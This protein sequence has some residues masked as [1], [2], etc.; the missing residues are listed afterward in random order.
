MASMKIHV[1]TQELEG[2]A[3]RY[4]A[5]RDKC[6]QIVRQIMNGATRLSGSWHGEAATNYYNKLSQIQGD[7]ETLKRIIDEQ[8]KDLRAI[9]KVYE[10]AETEAGAK[11]TAI[12]AATL[13]F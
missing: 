1:S 3:T 9:A 2:A 4:D 8:A 7:L 13:S 6:I 12:D 11:A 5:S 10:K